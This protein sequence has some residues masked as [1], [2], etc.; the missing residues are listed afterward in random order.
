MERLLDDLE[1]TV[2]AIAAGGLSETLHD[3]WLTTSLTFPDELHVT[4]RRTHT[5]SRSGSTRLST[6]DADRVRAAPAGA[7]R[8]WT[9]WPVR[10]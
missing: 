7:P 2:L 3:R 9:P 10:A 4:G 6:A 8:G 5:G 1:D